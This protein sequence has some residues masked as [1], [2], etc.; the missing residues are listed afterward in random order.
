MTT[1]LYTSG[2][3]ADSSLKKPYGK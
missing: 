2:P 3:A 1:T